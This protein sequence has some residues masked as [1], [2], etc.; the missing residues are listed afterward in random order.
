M[1]GV[2]VSDAFGFSKI[3]R[4]VDVQKGV[5]IVA[6]VDRFSFMSGLPRLNL[7]ATFLNIRFQIGHQASVR[8]HDGEMGAGFIGDAH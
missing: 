1:G 4:A 5:R 2:S 7:S 6:K 8:Q 3:F